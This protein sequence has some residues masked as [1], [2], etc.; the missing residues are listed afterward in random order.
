MEHDD[1]GFSVIR[2]KP[3][4][5]KEHKVRIRAEHGERKHTYATG[6]AE[7]SEKRRTHDP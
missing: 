2:R 7:T 1:A 4:S 5:E 3:D 6:K